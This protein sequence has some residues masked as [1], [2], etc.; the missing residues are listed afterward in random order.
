MI[1][2]KNRGKGDSQKQSKKENKPCLLE[3]KIRTSNSSMKNL[4]SNS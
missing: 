4:F 1:L 3:S 2:S